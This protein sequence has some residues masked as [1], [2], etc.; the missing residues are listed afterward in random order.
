MTE[1]QFIYMAPKAK[2]ILMS[3][4]IALMTLCSIWWFSVWAISIDT[5]TAQTSI[6]AI[7]T[8]IGFILFP[9]WVVLP[10]NEY[11]ARKFYKKS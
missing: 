1:E 7:W 8:Y 10:G 3:F 6:P 2:Y 9:S 4:S 11:Y 5:P